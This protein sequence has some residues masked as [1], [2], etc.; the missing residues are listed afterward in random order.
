MW[1]TLVAV[2]LAFL[3][4]WRGTKSRKPAWPAT[5]LG[6]GDDPTKP[7]SRAH[8]VGLKPRCGPIVANQTMESVMWD[9]IIN[10]IY[11]QS[12]RNYRAATRKRLWA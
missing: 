10:L 2:A 5:R 1:V 12:C 8:E 9:I 11:H 3:L 7:F 4:H 6:G